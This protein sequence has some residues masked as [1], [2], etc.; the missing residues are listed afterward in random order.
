M[1][2]VDLNRFTSFFFALFSLFV[3]NGYLHLQTT[4][5]RGSYF[6]PG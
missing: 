3:L 1:N 2:E 6:Q 4:H 5:L